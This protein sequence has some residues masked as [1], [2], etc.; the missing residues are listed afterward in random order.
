MYIICHNRKVACNII[1]LL[2]LLPRNH[3]QDSEH[4]NNGVTDLGPLLKNL[5]VSIGRITRAVDG[6]WNSIYWSEIL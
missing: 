5:R 4:P 3:L 2:L 1:K 6:I